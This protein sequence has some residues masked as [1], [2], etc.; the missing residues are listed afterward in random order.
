[1]VHWVVIA[2][3]S[4]AL[5]VAVVNGVSPFHQ[6]TMPVTNTSLPVPTVVGL[7][8]PDV[9]DV[10]MSFSTTDFGFGFGFSSR[11]DRTA[12]ENCEL[13]RTGQEQQSSSRPESEANA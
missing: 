9:P 4:A 2:L 8:T 11:S 6:E 10:A 1:V 5:N 7:Q 3:S 12:I 13:A